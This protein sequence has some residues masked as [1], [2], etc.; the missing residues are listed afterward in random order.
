MNTLARLPF[1]VL[2][3]YKECL[4]HEFVF[5]ACRDN[6]LA[7]SFRIF[8]LC[9]WAS[10]HIFSHWKSQMALCSFASKLNSL[11]VDVQ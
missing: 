11:E 9:F 10:V 3:G 8:Q 7:G 1:A 2:A 4:F 5:E 6:N